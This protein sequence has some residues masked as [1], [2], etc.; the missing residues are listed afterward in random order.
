MPFIPKDSHT[1]RQAGLPNS[2]TALYDKNAAG[3][4]V[5]NL[6]AQVR[7][8]GG[9]TSPYAASTEVM[10]R[11]IGQGTHLDTRA[12]GKAP[13]AAGVQITKAAP[14]ARKVVSPTTAAAQ[15]LAS[16]RWGAPK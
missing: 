9:A 2:D 10:G 11:G 1:V 16:R 4:F 7:L 13:A 8:N 12:M 5:G 3:V 15:H 6:Q 14:V